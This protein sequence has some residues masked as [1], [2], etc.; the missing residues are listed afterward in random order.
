MR[1]FL[2][3]TTRRLFSFSLIFLMLTF[4]FNCSYFKA[5]EGDRAAILKLLSKKKVKDHFVLNTPSERYHFMIDEVD[6][7][8]LKGR[9]MKNELPKIHYKK[10]RSTRLARGERSIYKEVHFYTNKEFTKGDTTV[11]FE[12]LTEIRIID[13]NTGAN[14]A[15]FIGGLLIVGVIAILIVLATKSSCPFIY[16]HN[17]ETFAFEGEVF[18]GAIFPNLERHDYMPLPHLQAENGLYKLRISNELKEVQYTNLAHLISVQH[19]SNTQVLLDQKGQPHLIDQ[20]IAPTLAQSSE[21]VNLQKVLEA[22]DDQGFSFMEMNTSNNEVVMTFPV[23]KNESAPKIVLKAKNSLWFDWLYGEFNEKL[24]TYYETYV[25]N[26]SSRPTEELDK[27]IADRQFPLTI[28]VKTDNGWEVIEDLPTIGPLAARDFV[29]PVPEKYLDQE[30][31]EIK[32]STGFYFWEVDYVGMSFTDN[33]GL[34]VIETQ[35][36][37]LLWGGEDNTL[38]DILYDDDRYLSQLTEGEIVELHYPEIKLA[39]GMQ[40]SHFLH[41]KGYY[42]HVRNF[43][44]TPDVAELLKFKD[45][46]HFNEFSKTEYLNYLIAREEKLAAK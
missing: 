3:P 15:T 6:N 17:G 1:N 37:D 21:G 19:P 24:G 33:T 41:A 20:L 11:A 29:I 7:N 30:Q 27:A 39:E 43:S 42:Q 36:N 46:S 9:L 44:N 23:P 25:E 13:P 32:I 26:Q 2:C 14:I 12:D 34:T 31:I 8:V 45:P 28:S 35:P 16:V 18:G 5:K 38:A 4:T 22:K 10:G 40:Q